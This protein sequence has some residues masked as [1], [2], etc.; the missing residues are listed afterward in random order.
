MKQPKKELVARQKIREYEAKRMIVENIPM[1]LKQNAVLI[2]P[3]TNLDTLP[4]QYPWLRENKL[5]VKPDQLF[6]KRKKHNLVLVNAAFPQVQEFI[7][8]HRNKEITIGKTTD[9]L[10]HF[11]I[12]PFIPHEEEYYISIVSQR[13]KD[14]IYYSPEGGINIEENWEN[15]IAI[16]IPTLTSMDTIDINQ[17]IPQHKNKEI[18][19]TF[20]KSLYRVF[21]DLDF[22][23]LE[24]NPFAIGENG[25]IHLLDTVAYLDSCAFFKNEQQWNNLAFPKEFGKKEF[26]EEQ[27]IAELDK[28]SGASLK[29][30]I[31][32]P[33]GRIWNILSGGGASIIF[34]D[35]IVQHGYGLEIANY[36]EY[37]GNPSEEESYQYAKTILDLMIRDVSQKKVLIIAGAI[38]NFTDIEKT[39][40]GI[41]KA[42]REYASQLRQGTISIFVRRGG[43]NDKKGLALMEEAGKELDLPV[44]VFGPDVP[45]VDIVP[46]A[47]EALQ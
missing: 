1:L 9:T 19:I 34:M 35:T 14:I 44:H 32:N 25:T 3:E 6:G 37:S 45:L 22:T 13:D 40:R 16:E 36:G 29:L 28:N 27:Y 33:N 10:T 26:P 41:V 11:I 8:Q 7:T 23:Y 31:L 17:K 42:L 21:L 46:K 30:T 47:L 39:F 43:P 12:E 15:V 38:A 2:T 5:V 18:I 24:V 4:Q 20:I